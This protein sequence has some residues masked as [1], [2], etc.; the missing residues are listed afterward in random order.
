MNLLAR[1]SVRH[2]VALF[3][4]IACTTDAQCAS[5]RQCRAGFCELANQM[6]SFVHREGSCAGCHTG[7]PSATTPGRVYIQA[8]P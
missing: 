8:A 4:A 1:L 5:P 2:S 3:A 6:T 7:D